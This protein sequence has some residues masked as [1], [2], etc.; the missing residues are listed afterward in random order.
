MDVL[1][2][3]D[4]EKKERLIIS[5]M[6]EFGNNQFAKASTNN[7]VKN[8]GISKGLLF[9]YFENKEALY[10]YLIEFALKTISEPITKEIGLEDRDI[11]R[12][13]QRISDLKIRIIHKY[14]SLLNFSK[15][16]FIGMDYEAIFK[17]IQK[18]HTI[19]LNDYYT[20]N[21]DT[22]MFKEDIDVTL[23]VKT[24]Q[25]TFERISE[26]VVQQRNM[27]IEPDIDAVLK[28]ISTF[29]AH[30]RRIYYKE[31]AQ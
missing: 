25:Y 22:T 9:H 31:E 16:M 26:D 1:D 19:P 24:I 29:L 3:M 13:L 23:A 15:T 21:I 28:E 27:G 30:F 14:P 12:R 7:I 11:I 20:A 2:K 18:Y 4:P 5:A 17:F 10:N 8:A 6:E